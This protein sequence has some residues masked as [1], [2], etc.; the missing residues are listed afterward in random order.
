MVTLGNRFETPSGLPGR[1]CPLLP[2][3]VAWGLGIAADRELGQVAIAGIT[4]LTLYTLLGGGLLGLWLVALRGRRGGYACLLAVFALLAAAHH[5]IVWHYFSPTDIGAVAEEQPLPVCLRLVVTSVPEPLE[6]PPPDPLEVFPEEPT[7]RFSARVVALRNGREWEPA[8]G[9]L[10]VYLSLVPGHPAE[11][12]N[13]E[14]GSVD[15]PTRPPTLPNPEFLPGE[16]LQVLGRLRRPTTKLNPG[17]FDVRTY[18]R[19]DRILAELTIAHPECVTRLKPASFWN[20][21]TLLGW[22]RLRAAETLRVH[23]SEINRPLAQA[24][25]LGFR[26]EIPTE[27]EDAMLKTG[28]LHL[29]AISGLHVGILAGV[30]HA[31]LRRLRCPRRWRTFLLIAVILA[32]TVLSGAQPSTLRAATTFCLLLLGTL[33][34]QPFWS[35]NSLALAGWIVLFVNPVYLFRPGPQL[36][37]LA[38]SVLVV[39]GRQAMPTEP[40]PLHEDPQQRRPKPLRRFWERAPVTVLLLTAA[41]WLISYP[42]VWYSFK[43]FSPLGMVLTPLLILPITVALV[44]GFLLLFLAPFSTLVAGLAARVCDLSLTTC[45]QIIEKT[46]SAVPLYTWQPPPPLGWVVACYLL[47]IAYLLFAGPKTPRLTR[48][49]RAIML[50][51][52]AGGMVFLFRPLDPR[53]TP[54]QEFR[55]T[56]LSIGHGLGT[57]FQTP[58]GDVFLYDVGSMSS[59][60]RAARIAAECLWHDGHRHVDAVILSHADLDHYNGL[61]ALSDYVR[62]RKLV[63]SPAMFRQSFRQEPG[64]RALQEVIAQNGLPVEEL[65]AGAEGSWGSC[66]FKVLHPSDKEFFP[67]DNANSL[68]LLLEVAGRRVL[69][70]GDVEG[71]GLESLLRLPPVPVDV[72]VAP[73]HGTTNSHPARLI[74]W[75]RPRYV[76]ISGSG[77]SLENTTDDTVEENEYAAWGAQVFHTAEHG[78]VTVSVSLDDGSYEVRE[79]RR[80]GA[81]E[82]SDTDSEIGPP[83]GQ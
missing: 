28:T 32:Y 7:V 81:A 16:T 5:H 58:E 38:A 75:C 64:I 65:A 73:H 83:S 61:P 47:W 37:F 20:P 21:A 14:T 62:I 9:R 34:H 17:D 11:G 68:V 66:R 78:A 55:M 6:C 80:S 35:L 82:A 15:G 54:R 30:C 29:L 67:S 56:V 41:I 69:L 50:G 26:Q 31:T 33:H 52:L 13:A 57:V 25:L 48:C 77:G 24:L 8:T 44:S 76:I 22:W 3:L 60:T 43:I 51:C 12:E 53:H 36:S 63:V 42:L 4:T 1:F 2:P 40:Q 49:L 27:L 59:A 72:L 10:I 39:V 70:T 74:A 19:G 23:L 45:R 79:F 71:P 46:V 18:R